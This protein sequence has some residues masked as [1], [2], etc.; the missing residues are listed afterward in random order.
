VR[1]ADHQNRRDISTVC[2]HQKRWSGLIAATEQNDTIERIGGNRLLHV[3][4]HQITIQHSSRTHVVFPQRHNREFER[5]APSLPDAALHRFRHLP[6][7]CITV[8]QLAPRIA[9]ANNWASLVGRFTKTFG[10]E[11]SAP[12]PAIQL[13]GVKPGATAVTGTR[14]GRHN[15]R[16]YGYRVWARRSAS[17]DYTSPGSL[18]TL[19]EPGFAVRRAALTQ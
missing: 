4:A 13:G 12:Q 5:E 9:N 16:S 10:F 7:V 8:R 1:P 19:F 3:H 17:S 2:P 6:Q 18:L 15:G 11:S 14:R